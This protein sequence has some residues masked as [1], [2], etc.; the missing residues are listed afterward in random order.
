MPGDLKIKNYRRGAA[1]ADGEIKQQAALYVDKR[2][3]LQNDGSETLARF[4]K[5]ADISEA[6]KTKTKAE[7]KS[8]KPKSETKDE[9]LKESAHNISQTENSAAR[10]ETSA[11]IFKRAYELVRHF[12]EVRGQK[13]EQ[14]VK[15]LSEYAQALLI[16]KE[17][18]AE[19][20]KEENLQLA[21]KI[22]EYGSVFDRAGSVDEL[23]GEIR[24]ILRRVPTAFTETAALPNGAWF[25]AEIYMKFKDAFSIVYEGAEKDFAAMTAPLREFIKKTGFDV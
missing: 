1:A 12:F 11:E 7:I 6:E 5:R 4:D 14:I 21:L 16:C 20:P 9:G 13:A 3:I 17:L 18:T 23:S 24:K 8:E 10:R 15:S 22:S 2:H 25:A 19:Q